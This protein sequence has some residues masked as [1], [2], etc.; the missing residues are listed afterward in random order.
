MT[1]QSARAASR[2]EA[3][4]RVDYPN[5]LPRSV[6]IMALDEQAVPLVDRIV[7][8]D[9]HRRKLDLPAYDRPTTGSVPALKEWMNQLTARARSLIADIAPGD[10][11]VVVATA[12]ED[13]EPAGLI[14]EACRH[15]GVP[16][17]ALIVDSL[18]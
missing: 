7:A 14:G 6:K 8:A 17:T 11:V 10:L 12:G 18:S 3:R 5:S 1:S 2:A 4:F 13:A 16:V 15:R 9:A